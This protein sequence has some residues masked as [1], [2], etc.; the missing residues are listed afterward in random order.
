MPNNNERTGS[1]RLTN[2]FILC[3]LKNFVGLGSAGLPKMLCF[4]NCS[5]PMAHA[6]HT[7]WHETATDSP[8]RE[9]SVMKRRKERAALRQHGKKTASSYKTPAGTHQIRRG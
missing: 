8:Q 2:Q 6:E 9:D 5:E 3:S 1:A 7:A 4:I